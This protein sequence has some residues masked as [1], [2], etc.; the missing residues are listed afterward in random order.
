MNYADLGFDSIQSLLKR[1]QCSCRQIPDYYLN[2]INE[3]KHLNAFI[4]ILGEQA[5][6]RAGKIDRKLARSSEG[7]L[8]GLIVAVKDN[9]N[10]KGEKTTC[11]SKILSNFISPYDATVSNR[12][13]SYG[14]W[15]RR[16]ITAI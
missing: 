5:L 2:R 16:T 3:G 8:T 12:L 6:A 4:S 13:R 7:K 1:N 9:I 10:I 14:N 15:F 11:G